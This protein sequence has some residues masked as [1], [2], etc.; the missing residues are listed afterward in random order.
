MR[1][2]AKKGL[3]LVLAAWGIF[4]GWAL[5]RWIGAGYVAREWASSLR[6]ETFQPYLVG[7]HAQDRREWLSMCLN[8]DNNNRVRVQTAYA[9]VSVL[10]TDGGNVDRYMDG[11]CKIGRAVKR[12]AK[13]DAVMLMFSDEE[14]SKRSQQLDARARLFGGWTPCHVDAIQGPVWAEVAGN[15]YLENKASKMELDFQSWHPLVPA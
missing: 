1:P 13:I 4:M 9:V 3:L 7:P 14:E 8:T 10:R 5:V 2:T 12:F 15:P 11:A 6:Q